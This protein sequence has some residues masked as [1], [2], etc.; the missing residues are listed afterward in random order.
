MLE[1]LRR[2]LSKLFGRRPARLLGAVWLSETML[3][4]LLESNDALEGEATASTQTS[5][6]TSP[7]D[8]RC[9]SY[10]EGNERGLA[11]SV[12]I[13]RLPAA[14]PA[15]QPREVQLRIGRTRLRLGPSDL[16]SAPRNVEPALLAMLEGIDRSS[17]AGLLDFVTRSAIPELGGRDTFSL[18]SNVYRLRDTLRERLPFRT[19]NGDEPLSVHVDRLLAI[20][21]TSFWINGWMQDARNAAESVLAI[22]PEGVTADLLEG[23]YRHSRRDVEELFAGAEGESAQQHGFIKL[24]RLPAPSLLTAGWLAQANTGGGGGVEVEAPAVVR[25]LTTVRDSILSDT[26]W[27][28]PRTFELTE[29]HVHPALDRIQERL[30]GTLSIDRVVQYGDPPPAPTVTLIVPLYERIDFVQHQMAQF[31]RDPEIFGTDV[32]FALDTPEFADGLFKE[33]AGLHQF[34]GIPFRVAITNRN[35]GFSTVNN[36]AAGLARGRLLVLMNSDVFPHRP[37]WIGHMA[38]FYDATPGVGALGPKLLYED[39]SLQHAGMY[40]ERQAESALWGTLHYYKGFHRDFPAANV[41]RPVPAVT[42]A[43]LMVDRGLYE[44]TG[45]LRDIF[46]KGGYE[47]SDLCLRLIEMGRRN[48]Y[49]PAVALYHLEDQSYSTSSDLRKL[50]TRYNTWLQTHLWSDRI[51]ELMRADQQPEDHP[52][53]VPTA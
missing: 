40:F 29:R 48:W 46:V 10:R 21:E 8:V 35:A 41:A 19:V 43:C 50:V 39:D 25:D 11:R 9:R 44:S 4:V 34:Y 52:A 33:A 15:V 24:L 27:D 12:A 32:I 36:L 16:A 45:G 28:G 22:S 49:L 38:A 31:A 18:A 20:D 14:E 30:R 23:A 42:G 51:E 2:R 37:G 17:G 7:V 13:L 1:R 53:L 6:G 26:G 3:L 5:G 47:D